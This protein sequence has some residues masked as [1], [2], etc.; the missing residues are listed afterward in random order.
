MTTQHISE[1]LKPKPFDEG[2]I[3]D[4]LE[5]KFQSIVV[6]GH[7]LNKS[8]TI[9]GSSLPISLFAEEANRVRPGFVNLVG[10]S[11]PEHVRQNINTL[12]EADA[13]IING[14]GFFTTGA[15]VPFLQEMEGKPLFIYLHETEFAVVG[16][17]ARHPARVPLFWRTLPYMHILFSTQ[18]QADWYRSVLPVEG[19]VVYNAIDIGDASGRVRVEEI[20]S[21][22]PL[23]VLNVATVQDRKGPQ[24]FDKVAQIAA[25]KRM[26]MEFTWVGKKTDWLSDSF[27]FSEAVNWVG[28]VPHDDVVR[29]MRAS[30]LFFL[31]SIDDPLPLSTTEAAYNGMRLVSYSIPGSEELFREAPGYKSFDE[32]D[33]EAALNAIIHVQKVSAQ[34]INYDEILQLLS[35][36]NLTKRIAVA[37]VLH[38]ENA[39]YPGICVVDKDWQQ[40]I[41]EVRTQIAPGDQKENIKK[42]GKFKRFISGTSRDLLAAFGEWVLDLEGPVAAKKYLKPLAEIRSDGWKQFL[43]AAEDEFG[44]GRYFEAISLADEASS[45]R[46]S[47]KEAKAI[48]HAAITELIKKGEKHSKKIRNSPNNNELNHTAERFFERLFEIGSNNPR[49]LCCYSEYLQSSGKNIEA[50]L[51]IRRTTLLDPKIM[52]YKRRFIFLILRLRRWYELRLLLRT[53]TRF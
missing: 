18:K 3:L 48:R 38:A 53:I 24:L 10:I 33:A 46:P 23:R 11:R 6:V 26:N 16:A 31:S 40:K 12:I 1:N 29:Y 44:K 9:V 22:S 37:M 49:I 30:D 5:G 50:L 4:V 7:D 51:F 52:K 32:Y 2:S 21:S 42:L 17:E 34:H 36:P 39:I 41:E 19:T 45:L 20:S 14:L 13:V 25:N 8:S 15:G 27:K 43:K 47:L 28:Q 35:P